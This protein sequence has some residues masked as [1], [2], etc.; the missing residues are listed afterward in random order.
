MD[1][2]LSNLQVGVALFDKQHAEL[3][4]MFILFR[5]LLEKNCSKSCVL[6]M[7]DL[8]MEKTKIHLDSE[9]EMMFKLEFPGAQ[10]HKIKH[11][12]VLE[13]MS[14]FKCNYDQGL[15]DTDLVNFVNDLYLLM[16]MH[17][18]TKDKLYSSFLKENGYLEDKNELASSAEPCWDNLTNFVNENYR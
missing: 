7:I 13:H 2:S 11:D 8:M 15:H 12:E 4:N 1:E 14:E 17:I 5:E 18:K 6:S 9:E 10:A 16:I 3:A